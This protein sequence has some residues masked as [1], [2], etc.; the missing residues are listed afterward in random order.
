[1]KMVTFAANTTQTLRE[2][3]VCVGLCC[4]CDINWL[5]KWGRKQEEVEPNWS[6]LL[7]LLLL[8]SRFVSQSF[9]LSWFI[10]A[11]INARTRSVMRSLLISLC[12]WSNRAT[13]EL[14]LALGKYLDRRGI[15]PCSCVKRLSAKWIK[16]LDGGVE[17]AAGVA[18][19]PIPQRS[20]NYC[21]R[22]AAADK[23]TTHL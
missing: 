1:M 9:T 21:E 11:W 20:A 23:D 12:V 10:V 5:K 4:L 19:R 18:D 22:A 3:D 13:S 2:V 14:R 7:S 16:R 15:K 8:T 6:S 17:I